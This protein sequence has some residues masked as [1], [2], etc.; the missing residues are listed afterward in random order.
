MSQDQAQAILSNI[1]LQTNLDN[2]IEIKELFKFYTVKKREN[3]ERDNL[4]AANDDV[5]LSIR[6]GEVFGLL[7]PNGAGKTTLINQILG[8][9]RPSEGS[10]FVE[11]INVVRRPQDVK[12]VS[13]YLPQK[14]VAF[15]GIEV[16]KAILYNAI[17]KGLTKRSAE[18]QT[19]QLIAELDL[20]SVAHRFIQDLSGGMKRIVG[21]T[22]ALSGH[23]KILVLDEPTNELD[24]ARRRQVWETIR[25]INRERGTTTILVTHNVLEAESVMDR[26]A[27]MNN[28]R[29]LAL[30][31]PGELK[32]QASNQA[33]IDLTL[34][35]AVLQ[36]NNI[37]AVLNSLLEGVNTSSTFFARY[38]APDPLQWSVIMPLEQAQQTLARITSKLG[39]LAYIDD[40]KLALTSLEDVYLK[41]IEQDNENRGQESQVSQQAD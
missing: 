7:G 8:L 2:S 34:K 40:L 12:L 22:L 29:L 27:I 28:G 36:Q 11:G 39:G 30:G 5:T 26:T 10:I 37:K 20:E 38:D 17:L 32:Q 25:K 24:P 41:L 31:S 6:R 35:Q 16:A 23:P 33:R 21:L 4:L 18:T 1:K 14:L 3:K 15:E 13:S 9:T 19:A